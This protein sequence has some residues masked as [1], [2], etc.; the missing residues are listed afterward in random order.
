MSNRNDLRTGLAGHSRARARQLST[1]AGRPQALP[2]PH[3]RT[4][5]SEFLPG[6]CCAFLG[7]GRELVSKH[8]CPPLFLPS[9]NCTTQKP[10]KL[11][12][13]A[14]PPEA[15]ERFERKSC[16]LRSSRYYRFGSQGFIFV[17]TVLFSSC[18][19][20]LRPALLGPCCSEWVRHS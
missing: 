2:S 18:L 15:E 1:P 4:G 17:R 14:A 13:P 7:A 9:L 3:T 10:R 11:A 5:G 19:W 12:P 20:F 16:C 8:H 6:R